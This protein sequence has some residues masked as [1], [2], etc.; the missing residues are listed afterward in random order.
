MFFPIN[1]E[2]KLEIGDTTSIWQIT[3]PD[4][5]TFAAKRTDD[6]GDQSILSGQI[7]TDQPRITM[8]EALQSSDIMRS[9]FT[10]EEPRQSVYT[11]TWLDCLTP[12][13]PNI[14]WLGAG[15]FKLSRV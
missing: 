4:D 11:G 6:L 2:W 5:A 15:T 3:T 8:M 1:S 10:V 9:F 13:D 7:I 12:G 14:Q